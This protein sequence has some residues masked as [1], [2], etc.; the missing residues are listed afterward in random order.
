MIRYKYSIAYVACILAVN[1]GFVYVP[2][3]PLLGEMWPPMSLLV[4]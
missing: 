4:V 2:P 3:M 1:I